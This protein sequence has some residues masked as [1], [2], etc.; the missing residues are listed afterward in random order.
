MEKCSTISYKAFRNAIDEF[1]FCGTE[2][3]DKAAYRLNKCPRNHPSECYLENSD[4]NSEFVLLRKVGVHSFNVRQFYGK[5]NLVKKA[6]NFLSDLDTSLILKDIDYIIKL[7]R[8]LPVT[9]SKVL[10]NVS[11]KSSIVNEN[12]VMEQYGDQYSDFLKNIKDLPKFTCISCEVLIKPSEAKVITSRRKKLDN[13]SFTKLK[14]YLCSERRASIGKEKVGNKLNKHLCNYCNTKLNNNE[15]PRVSVINDFDAGK[16]PAEISMLNVFS[17]LFIKLA[18]SFQ[19]HL[20]LGPIH[21]YVPKNQKMVGV[22]GNS[23]QLPIPI[24]DTIEE[25]A[26][27]LLHNTLL[28]VGKHLLI[29]NE[30]KSKKVLYKNL[31]NIHAIKTAL[32]WLK[33]NNPHY[34][35]IEIPTN[36]EEL[37]SCTENTSACEVINED[38]ASK[39]TAHF[40][41]SITELVTQDAYYDSE[42]E[43]ML[44]DDTHNCDLLTQDVYQD[45]ESELITHND[46]LEDNKILTDGEYNECEYEEMI[47]QDI[48]HDS[49][50]KPEVHIVSNDIFF[51][52][53]DSDDETMLTQEQFTASTDGFY[54][55]QDEFVASPNSTML[56]LDEYIAS[57][58]STVLTVDEYIASTN[59]TML[60]VDEFIAS[61]NSTRLTLDNCIPS[62]NNTMLTL[63]DYIASTSGTSMLTLDQYSASTTG[64]TNT[65]TCSNSVENECTKICK[66]KTTLQVNNL[67]FKQN[68]SRLLE[69]LNDFHLNHLIEQ[70]TVTT[71]NTVS[72]RPDPEIYD[73]LYKL[74]KI[75]DDPI[76]SEHPKL[77][78]YC[79]PHLFPY[80]IGGRKEEKE[81]AQPM[82][83][84]KTRII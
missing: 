78:M 54:L 29:Y 32:I 13:D 62:T 50:V 79:F 23:V 63:D 26:S 40:T 70:Y 49:Q 45:S 31:V 52:Q 41:D 9:K 84:E 68:D 15:T 20:K 46:V 65:Q 10:D 22:K 16:C 73:S 37:L 51:T 76:L 61:T 30:G 58:N 34:A 5:L 25:L 7:T 80:G 33:S 17:S 64:V 44:F 72:D 18:S 14:Q 67:N 71:V 82:R 48:Y 59:N 69:N 6:H 43:E 83:Y 4:C 24:Q 53:N 11:R 28:D 42:D 19:T 21:A 56:T 1:D 57:T 55:T 36:P 77:D 39:D 12:T 8:Y 66:E 35:Y 38:L 60:T 3:Q 74:L 81:Q 2:T 75:K 47:T 27:N